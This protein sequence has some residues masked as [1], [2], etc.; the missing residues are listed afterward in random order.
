MF[1]SV[2]SVTVSISTLP[3]ESSKS[4]IVSES[5]EIFVLS[6]ISVLGGV[7]SDISAKCSSKLLL[8]SEKSELKSKLSLSLLPKVAF[9]LSISPGEIPWDPISPEG[10]GSEV[11][12]AVSRRLSSIMVLFIF[13]KGK[14]TK[15][16]GI[17]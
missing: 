2:W 8:F 1:V 10:P 5:I 9:D 11:P 3:L 12:E 13:L 7:T 16:L 4:A 15:A 6:K 17:A 14:M